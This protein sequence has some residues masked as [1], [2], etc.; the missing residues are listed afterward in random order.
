MITAIKSVSTTGLA[1]LWKGRLFLAGVAFVAAGMFLTGAATAQAEG[2]ELKIASFRHP[3][4]LDPITGSSGY[5]H[6]FL[7]PIYDTLIGMNP[8][9]LELEPALAE[10]WTFIDTKTLV[11]ALRAGVKESEGRRV[12]KEWVGTGRSRWG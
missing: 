4:T 6:T 10:K 2:S 3:T 12:G 5:D 8:K 11:L 7:Y 1:R 9:T